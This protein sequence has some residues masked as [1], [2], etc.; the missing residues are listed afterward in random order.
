[1]AEV[2]ELLEEKDR[3]S[4][5]EEQPG[6]K[7]DIEAEESAEEK[8]APKKKKKV[9][10]E[11]QEIEKLQQKLTEKNDQF[12][13]LRA[14]YDNFRKRSQSEKSAVYGSAVSDTVNQI[15]PVM[16]NIERALKL[17]KASAED[18]IK[19]VEMIAN[20][21]SAS[22][23]QLGVKEIGEKGEA[24]DPNLHNAVSHI[25][26]DALGENVIAEV[27]RKGYIIG[28]RVVRHAM[29]QVAN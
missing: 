16:D 20:Q 26:D 22:F 28:D 17:E 21:F 11:Q 3:R 6:E 27:L 10:K 15:L 19:G 9:T 12:L 13:R 1:M 4:P 14:E 18:M 25:D 8:E 23:E 24:F 2:K 7:P 29:V 5:G